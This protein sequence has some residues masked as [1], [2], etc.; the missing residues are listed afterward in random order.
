MADLTVTAANVVYVS[1]T[2]KTDKNAAAT[3]T[4]GQAL[5]FD[6]SSD[7][8]LGDC[9]SATASVRTFEGISLG[10][11]ADNQPCVYQIDGDINLGATLVPGTIY[12]M[13]ATAGGIAPWA[14]LTTDDYVCL[15]GWAIST[16]V[17]RMFPP[18]I[19]NTGIQ[20]P[21]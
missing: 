21:A 19:R 20:I 11:S 4:A 6:S 18:A 3:I 2:K 15:V 10:P 9:D 16:S 14:D 17:L 13:S 12:V 7:M 1:G 8:V 5:A